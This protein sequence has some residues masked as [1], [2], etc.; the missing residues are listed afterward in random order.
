MHSI[1]NVS[2]FWIKMEALTLTIGQ[3]YVNTTATATHYEFPF[4]STTN[5]EAIKCT[6]AYM[7]SVMQYLEQLGINFTFSDNKAWFGPAIYATSLRACSWAGRAYPFI[8]ESLF[9]DWPIFNFK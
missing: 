7:Q 5:T 3:Q 9:L 2:Y 8:N 1:L 4:L 6:N